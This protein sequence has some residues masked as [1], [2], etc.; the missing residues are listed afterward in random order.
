[1]LMLIPD[2]VYP[3]AWIKLSK[4]D[5]GKKSSAASAS[6]AGPSSKTI[7]TANANGSASTT[8]PTQEQGESNGNLRP[9]P[10]NPYPTIPS[11]GTCNDEADHDSHFT[12]EPLTIS[13]GGENVPMDV[14]DVD[15]T[16]MD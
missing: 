9:K 2:L 13:S 6:R 4:S 12:G 3:S 16:G 7:T 1:M 14:D 10:L 5:K 15:Q 11:D 8:K